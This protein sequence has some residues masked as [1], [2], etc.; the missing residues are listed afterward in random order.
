VSVI[1]ADLVERAH[2]DR[3]DLTIT[4]GDLVTPLAL[5]RARELR[6]RIVR[7][8]DDGHEAPAAAPTRAGSAPGLRT[9]GTNQSVSSATG[10]EA[11]GRL[12]GASAP[13]SV[14][15]GTANSLYRRGAPLGGALRPAGPVGPE[16]PGGRT[17]RSADRPRVAV[18]G[19]GHVG[20]ITTLRLAE[21][22]LFAEV[23][24]VDVVDG[25]AA[26]IALDL[27]HSAGLAR[28]A[29]TIRGSTDLAAITG[30]DYV[31]MTAGRARTPGMTRTDLTAANAAI[32]GP[33]ADRIA[34]L[35]PDSVVIMVTNPLEEMTH[36]AWI[37]SGLPAE[38]VLGMAGVLDSVRFCSLVALTGICRPQDVR[39]YAL[40]SHGPEMVVPLSQATVG[41]RPLRDLLDPTTLQG[42]VDRTRDSGAE[43]VSLL[44]TGSAYFAPG[45]SA[46]RM[47]I[48]MAKPAAGD[49]V[50]ACAVAPTGQYGLRDTRVGL[51]VRL[52]PRGLR[53]IV[54][55]PLEPAELQALRAA[56]DRLAERI[57]VRIGE[58]AD[59]ARGGV[60]LAR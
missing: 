8:G 3:A 30:V 57:G 32:V 58:V 1:G 36:L 35:A 24:L 5:E 54:E 6:V 13:R 53:E 56:G 34:E 42:I 27:W 4:K 44:K 26:G 14:G 33:V 59:D 60:L 12:G 46:A 20:S 15:P 11:S 10:A 19:A 9:A 50:L 16:Q 48:A 28:F 21:S 17:D 51:P 29:T 18:I 7:N 39:A 40:G 47:A 38:R 2:R 55:L 31:I 45:Q 23:V 49:E 52:G 37:R 41:G 25:L 43:V 22:D